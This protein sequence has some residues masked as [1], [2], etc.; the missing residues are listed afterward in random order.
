MPASARVFCINRPALLLLL[1]AA[2]RVPAPAAPPLDAVPNASAT[3]FHLLR[4]DGFTLAEVAHPWPGQA[5]TLRYLLVPRGTRLPAGFAGVP[6]VQ[7]PARRIVALSTTTLAG[8][9]KLGA[10]D[11]VVGVGDARYVFTPAVR[12]RLAS[13]AARSVGEGEAISAETI[14]AL[15][16][17]VVLMSSIGGVG[18]VARALQ[19]AGIPVVF[20]GDWAEATPL[21]RAE[22]LRFLAAFVD[23][24]ARADTLFG[25]IARRYSALARRVAAAEGRPGA[26][27]GGVF[28]GVWHAP[29]G[30]SY[31][32]ALLRDAGARYPWAGT[33]ET[34]S[35]QLDTETVLARAGD[36]AF[37][38][39][40]GAVDTRAALAAQDARYRLFRAFRE[41]DVYNFDRRVSPGGGFDFYETGVVEPDVVL[42]DLVRILHPDVLPR[43]ALVYYRR[44]P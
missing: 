19:A 12:A 24:G 26:F 1:L 33:P 40:P 39:N 21:G 25:G 17:D 11:A 6:V 4:G 14:A 31:M 29:G 9:D 42:A 18:A 35:L 36:A 43:H 20:V 13:G 41:G 22:W 3:G 30:G 7:T 37:W 32:A 5:D 8:L 34:G 15:Q 16:P 27:V 23:A 2:C 44:L 10:T 38:F 28:G